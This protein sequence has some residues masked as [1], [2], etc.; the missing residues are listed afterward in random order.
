VAN[1]KSGHRNIARMRVDD[2]CSLKLQQ[3]GCMFNLSTV[4]TQSFRRASLAA[5]LV[6]A[7]PMAHSAPLGNGTLLTIKQGG[8]GYPEG[9]C[10]GSYV[11]YLNNAILCY[12]IGPGSDGGLVVGKNQISG[13]Q[14]KAPSGN[15][16]K[17][18]EMTSAFWIPPVYATLATAPMIGAQEGVATTDAS[19]NRF[20]DVSCAGA[21][22]LGTVEINTLHMAIDGAVYP[23]GCAADDCTSTGGTGVKSWTVAADRTYKLDTLFGDPSVGQTQVHLE[24]SIV[25]PGN[26]LPVALPVT[27]KTTPGV[28]VNWKPVVSD[29][30]GDP[31][32]CSLENWPYAYYG[33]LTLA[34]DCSGGTYTPPNPLFTGQE[35][36]RYQVFDGNNFSVPAN[37]CVSIS[38]TV[39][40]TCESK[41]PKKQIALNGDGFG[42]ANKTLQVSFIGN[43]IRTSSTS[44]TACKS[45]PLSYT[46]ISTVGTAT[47]KVNGVATL[48][49]GLLAP[50]DTLTCT[51]K[52][53]GSDTDTFIIYGG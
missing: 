31:L 15:N 13:G 30:N 32:T 46:A 23:G 48:A 45:A 11:R 19:L 5:A 1:G 21:A 6:A 50:G 36:R 24:G 8:V 14:E 27:V 38:S 49:S 53:K 25:P 33:T 37:I 10:T 17:S 39:A 41:Y 43:I 44:V 12:P 35:C 42:A 9:T 7:A 4:S 29:A 3:G 28:P 34:A 47:C 16:A 40:S 2:L 52:P 26:T 18:G 20:D 51:N 22:C